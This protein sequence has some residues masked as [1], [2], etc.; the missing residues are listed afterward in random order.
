MTPAWL[1]QPERGSRSAIRLGAWLALKLGR[2]ATRWLLYPIC[3][4]FFVFSNSTRH[5]S[6]RYLKRVLGREANL[7]DVLRHYHTFASTVHDRIYLLRG[8]CNDFDISVHGGAEFGAIMAQGRGCILLGSHLGSFEVLRA[9]GRFKK[10]YPINIVMHEGNSEKTGA[11]LGPLAPELR[12]RV[13]APGRPD[14]LLK[15]KECLERGEI[16]G[17]LGDRAFGSSKT[18]TCRFLGEPAR[19]PSG[20]FLLAAALDTPMVLFFGIY[21]GGRR[22][23]IHLEPLDSE[24][25]VE[26]EPGAVERRVESYVARLEHYARRAPYNWF[27]FYDFWHDNPLPDAG[28]TK[29]AGSAL[30]EG[31]LGVRD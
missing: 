2:S 7:L 17:I 14:T 20:P 28:A 24:L 21:R 5:A 22:Y 18:R 13:I 25:L 9:L 8:R 29:E 12:S 16:V 15:V 27:N 1:S 3:C 31:R 26:R 6:R 30:A 23:E 10:G 4:Y 19:F 11:V